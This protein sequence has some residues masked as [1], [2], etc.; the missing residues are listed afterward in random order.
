MKTATA[1][2]EEFAAAAARAKPFALK[3]QQG[4]ELTEDENREYEATIVILNEIGPQ[5][6]AAEEREARAATVLDADRAYNQPATRRASG[7][8]PVPGVTDKSAQDGG[9]DRRSVGRRFTTSEAYQRARQNPTGIMKNDPFATGSFFARKYGF[10]HTDDLGPEELRALLYSGSPSASFLLPQ[11]L[12]TIYRGAE[13]PLVVRDVLINARTTSDAVTILQENVFTNAA[14]EVA[15][16]TAVN[17]GAKP[18]S[19]LTF[20]EVTYPVR[21]IGHWIPITRQLLEDLP[22]MES[23]VNDRLMIGLQR[24][25]DAEFIGGDGIAPNIT[26]ILNTSGIQT[27][28]ATYFTGAPVV[29]AGQSNENVNRILRARVKVMTTGAANATFVIMNPTDMEKVLTY[30]DANR[31]YLY[32][33][34]AVAGLNF[35]IWGLTPVWSENIT[36]GTALVGD[37]TMAAVFDRDEGRIYTTD[38]HSDF[39]IRNLFVILAE[40]RVALAVFRPAAFAKVALV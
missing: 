39:F 11:V 21:W 40:E 3:A 36:A 8:V 5:M 25:E 7:L 10:E 12:P 4:E 15:E 32:G 29:D 38:S 1:L 6:K 9:V 30:T 14:A 33:G 13:K 2:R 16:A 26:G 19:S 31:N 20:A 17:E 24:R 22:A 37:G 23:Y 34:P 28:D 35:T 18:E 27:L